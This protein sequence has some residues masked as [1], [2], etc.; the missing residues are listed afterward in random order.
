MDIYIYIYIYIYI[1]WRCEAATREAGYTY[2]KVEID[3]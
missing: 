1:C 2:I 3:R